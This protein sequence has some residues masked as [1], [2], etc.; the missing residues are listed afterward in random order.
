ML[1]A[2]IVALGAGKKLEVL[3]LVVVKVFLISWEDSYN[4]IQ[5]SSECNTVQLSIFFF[6]LFPL[7]LCGSLRQA[8][9][10]YVKKN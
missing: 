6:S 9:R 8:L 7:R 4:R 3:F 1:P 5:Y 2:T 10:V